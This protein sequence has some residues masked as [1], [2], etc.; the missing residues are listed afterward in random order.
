MPLFNIRVIIAVTLLSVY[1]ATRTT[2]KDQVLLNTIHVIK[3]LALVEP[4]DDFLVEGA[5]DGMLTK[6]REDLG[7]D[8]SGYIPPAYQKDF[9][10]QLE[11]KLEGIGVRFDPLTG[12]NGDYKVLFTLPDSP[13]E[14]A[15]IKSGDTILEIDG[16]STAGL[17]FFEVAKNIRGEA[18]TDVILTLKREGK[19]EPIE[20]AVT[21]AALQQKTVF[22]FEITESGKPSVEIPDEPGIG[23]IYITSFNGNTAS[24]MAELL[25]SMSPNV[26]ELIIDLRGNPGGYLDAVVKVADMFVDDRG[27]YKKIVSTKMRNGNVKPGGEFYATKNQLFTGPVVVLI[28]GGS[29]SAAEIFAACLQDFGRAKIVGE[30]TYGKGTVQEIF[31]LPLDLGTVKL[32]DASFWRP[33]ER[34]INRTRKLPKT[35]K[36][37]ANG[38]EAAKVSDESDDWGVTPD[39]GL[40]IKLPRQQQNFTK[41]LRELRVNVPN[42]K[43]HTLLTDYAKKLAKDETVLNILEYE[44]EEENEPTESVETGEPEKTTETKE[45][46]SDTVFKPEGNAP[47]YDPVL[48]QAIEVLKADKQ[49]KRDQHREL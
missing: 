6:M 5:L 15:G 37:S 35:G 13:A 38:E 47:Y 41:F 8:Y 24:E 22:G 4:S 7:D 34:N 46:E 9:K 14:K 20:I 31:E 36:N 19:E 27:T 11:S 25:Q 18:G 48:Q 44:D 21:R 32:T 30:R 17:S 49:V 3:S 2:L 10:E 23:Y 33:S 1:C 45:K 29:A 43:A 28:D 16:T 42:D 40:E 39:N 26:R 12:K